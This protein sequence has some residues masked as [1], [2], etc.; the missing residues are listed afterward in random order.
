MLHYCLP[1]FFFTESVTEAP[2]GTADAD[3]NPTLGYI[4]TLEFFAWLILCV[5]ADYIFWAADFFADPD[6][7]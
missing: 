7:N 5:C 4:H 6:T 3:V 1:L 2:N